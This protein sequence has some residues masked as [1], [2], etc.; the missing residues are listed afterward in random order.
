MSDLTE[1]ARDQS[2]TIQIHPW[3]SMDKE[4]TIFCHAPSERKGLSIKSPDWW[5]ADGCSVCHEIVD[6]KKR[7]DLSQDEIYR[8]FMRGVFRTLRRRIE[9]QGLIKT[10]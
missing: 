4:T 5:G 9:D 8:C 7:V 10:P 3:C 2:C 6:G 1:A